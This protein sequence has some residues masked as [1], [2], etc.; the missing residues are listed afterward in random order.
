MQ[1]LKR[2]SFVLIVLFIAAAFTAPKDF[3]AQQKKNQRVRTA[4][5][6]KGTLVTAKLKENNINADEL[7]ILIVAFKKEKQLVVYAKKKSEA[8]CSELSTYTI[9]SSSGKL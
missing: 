3:L 8:T 7:N 2:N 5:N 9:C 6:D 1:P 4:W